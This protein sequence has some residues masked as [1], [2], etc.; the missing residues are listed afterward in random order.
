MFSKNLGVLS[1]GNFY[2]VCVIGSGPSGTTLAKSLVERGVRTLILESGGSLF[3]WLVDIR[4]KKM[5]EYEVSGDVNYLKKWTRAR[6]L[7][8][9]SNFWTGR[10]ERFH[11]LDFQKNPYTPKLN[12]WPITYKEVEPYYEMAEK[13]LRV[14]GGSLSKY[15]PPRKKPLPIP[16]NPNISALKHLLDE[17]GITVD[18]SPTASPTK[19]W[20]FFRVQ[21]EIL[22]HFLTSPNASL[23]SGATVTRLIADSDGQITS[24]EVRNMKG[25]SR[26]ARARY[27]VLACGGIDSP[28]LL[29][30]SHS[31]EFPKGIGNTYSRVGRGFNE[32]PAIFYY[33]KIRHSRSTMYPRHEVGRSHQF[34]DAFKKEGFGSVLLGFIQSWISPNHLAMPRLTDI[35]KGV[36]SFTSRITRPTL[37]I[38]A[39]IEMI[40]T[41][42]NR[43]TLSTERKDRFGDPLAHLSLS[44]SEGD[45][46]TLDR[47]RELIETIYSNLGANNVEEA[48]LTWARHHIGACCMGNNPKTSVTDR[49]LRV[50]ETTNLYTCGSEVFVTGGAVPPTLTIV[51]LAH[52][53]ADHLVDMLQKNS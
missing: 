18:D 40:P 30:L 2:D 39:I 47:T 20:R 44:Y 27:Y 5:A 41:D 35:P 38:S 19:S 17:A 16:P 12:S 6:A 43:I 14:R 15:G 22:P 10:C 3:R 7:G 9:T 23:I 52:R 53:L 36:I 28:R 11:P 46:R 33:G 8:G 48:E 29:L 34:Y 4:L 26:I 21:K 42:N 1:N 31:K 24:V 25:E 45:I 32:H 50:H 49:N 13:T 37:N 51:A